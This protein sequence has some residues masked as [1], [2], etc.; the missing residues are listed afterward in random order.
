MS[1]RNHLTAKQVVAARKK[2]GSAWGLGRPL[3]ATELGR[4]CYL[5]GDSDPA[6]SVRNYEAEKS[7]VPP[8]VVALIRLYK[9]GVLPPDGIEIINPPVKP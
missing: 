5:G 8:M 6:R 4:A 7:T 3:T 2:I 1:R 9:S